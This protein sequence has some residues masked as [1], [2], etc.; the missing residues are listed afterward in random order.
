MHTHLCEARCAGWQLPRA[1]VWAGTGVKAGLSATGGL[2]E[3]C[4]PKFLVSGFPLPSHFW[5]TFFVC[6]TALFPPQA[7]NVATMGAVLSIVDTP[8][9]VAIVIAGLYFLRRLMLPKPIPNIPYNHDAASK[10]FGDVPELMGYVMR[11][12][13]VFVRSREEAGLENVLTRAPVLVD[14]LDPTTP[15]PYRPSLHQAH[16]STMEWW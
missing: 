10:M 4:S 7:T 6:F 8:V 12:Q 1:V 9:L 2:F 16:G 5:A 3:I 13:R 11:T 15:K 14:L